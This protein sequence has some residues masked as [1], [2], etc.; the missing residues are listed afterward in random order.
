MG[1]TRGSIGARLLGREDEESAV[2]LTELA[3]DS[4]SYGEDDDGMGRVER[5]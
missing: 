3:E 5:R 4:D 1:G 2:G